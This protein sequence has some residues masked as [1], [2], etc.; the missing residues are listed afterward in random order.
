[1]GGD[2]TSAGGDITSGAGD[3]ASADTDT[4]PTGG[5]TISEGADTANEG[6]DTTS[7]VGDITADEGLDIV[8]DIDTTEGSTTPNEGDDTAAVLIVGDITPTE[9]I[10]GEGA[11]GIAIPDEIASREIIGEVA[12]ASR[13]VLEN[14]TIGTTDAETGTAPELTGM[15]S[16]NT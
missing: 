6:G 11:E 12:A 13:A 8:G 1:V 15:N 2:I 3:I 7:E 4:T 16:Q 14:V 9:A 10:S 5:D